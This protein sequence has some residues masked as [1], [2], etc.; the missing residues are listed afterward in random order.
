VKR[1]LAIL[2]I[3][4]V[5]L[6]AAVIISSCHAPNTTVF[7]SSPVVATN[8]TTFQQ[9]KLTYDVTNKAARA[10]FLEVAAVERHSSAGWV[11]DTQVLA[12]HE[13]GTL[14]RVGANGI[15]RLSYQFPY[16]PGSQT[17]LRVSVAPE[18]TA[19]QKAHIAL[20]KLWANLRGQGHYKPLWFTTLFVPSYEVTT[21]GTP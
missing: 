19:V 12:A 5:T 14:G 1:M 3:A 8:G 20:Q 18:A 7:F 17:R 10:V 6:V 13:F 9:L 16:Q 15:A 2:I 4:V 21:P 11:A